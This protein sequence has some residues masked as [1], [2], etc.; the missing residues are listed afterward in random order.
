MGEKR[1]SQ[2][3]MQFGRLSAEPERVERGSKKN[4]DPNAHDPAS[5]ADVARFIAA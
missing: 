4:L 1:R 5:L 3:I 2:R